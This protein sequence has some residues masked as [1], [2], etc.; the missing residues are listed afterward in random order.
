MILYDIN[1]S[2]IEIPHR[3]P[4]DQTVPDRNI[5]YLESHAFMLTLLCVFLMFPNYVFFN[6]RR[7]H[8]TIIFGR[9]KPVFFC[10]QSMGLN[11][12]AECA[13]EVE[14]ILRHKTEIRNLVNEKFLHGLLLKGEKLLQLKIAFVT[15][16][17]S[18]NLDSFFVKS[19]TRDIKRL[20]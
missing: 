19:S 15:T 4:H 18:K 16:D 9:D 6:V 5:L 1:A 12:M 10:D 3:N 2:Q 17:C 8:Q 20:T 11:D 14:D 13:V 7:P